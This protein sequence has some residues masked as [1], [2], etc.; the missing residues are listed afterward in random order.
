[1]ILPEIVSH[2]EIIFGPLQ[3]CF[4]LID[5]FWTFTK[6][7]YKRTKLIKKKLKYIK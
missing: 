4:E 5:L 3:T 2:S 7:K 6:I 1:M